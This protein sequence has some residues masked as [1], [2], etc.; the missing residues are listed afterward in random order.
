MYIDEVISYNKKREMHN[1]WVLS[2]ISEK[3]FL[4]ENA[5][6]LTR[7]VKRFHFS[8]CFWALGLKVKLI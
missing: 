3:I 4:E 6:Q 5:Y 2:V 8:L 7:I 1:F